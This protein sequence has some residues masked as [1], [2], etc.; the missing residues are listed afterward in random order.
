MSVSYRLERLARRYLEFS[1]RKRLQSSYGV[2]VSSDIPLEY[3]MLAEA[4]NSCDPGLDQLIDIGAHKGYFSRAMSEFWKFSKII[5]VE[6]N[7]EIREEYLSK[8]SLDIIAV[9]YALA[10]DEGEYTY[11]KHPNSSMNS[12]VKAD[13]EAFEKEMKYYDVDEITEEKISARILDSLLEFIPKKSARTILLKLDTQGN[14]LAILQS[15][16]NLLQQVSVCIIEYMFW[17]GYQNAF[18]LSELID[19]MDD[20]GFNCVGVV[21]AK[22]RENKKP[23]YADFM[24]LAK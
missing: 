5:C 23:A 20:N 22:S 18:S 16:T 13:A 3:Y 8:L 2:N 15:G 24:F 12:I 4:I 21:N 17:R 19:F 11:Y 6:P 14:E 7:K 10:K 1:E 9:P